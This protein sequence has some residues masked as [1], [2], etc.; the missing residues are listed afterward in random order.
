MPRPRIHTLLALLALAHVVV[1]GAA[2]LMATGGAVRR[3]DT[4]R[5]ALALIISAVALGAVVGAYALARNGRRGRTALAWAVAILLVSQLALAT[6]FKDS[7]YCY[8]DGYSSGLSLSSDEAWRVSLRVCEP[9]RSHHYARLDLTRVEDRRTFTIPV[10][11]RRGSRD[12]ITRRNRWISMR[13]QGGSRYWLSLST[14]VAR[15][16]PQF[17]E[18]RVDLDPPELTEIRHGLELVDG[19]AVWDCDAWRVT[20]GDP[21]AGDPVLGICS[22]GGLVPPE[23]LCLMKRLARECGEDIVRAA[24]CRPELATDPGIRGCLTRLASEGSGWPAWDA[25][26]LIS[27]VADEPARTRELIAEAHDTEA[28]RAAPCAASRDAARRLAVARRQT[29]TSRQRHALVDLLEGR[30]AGEP[31][32]CGSWDSPF[33]VEWSASTARLSWEVAVIDRQWGFLDRSCARARSLFD[34]AGSD[35][36]TQLGD[37]QRRDALEWREVCRGRELSR[38]GI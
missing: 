14:A 34:G 38:R 32:R 5:M 23:R 11:V 21:R 4:A 33:A 30:A 7:R 36:M 15:H 19:R 35:A 1:A 25:L 2:W 20:D 12:A 16:G 3:P 29:S 24:I 28:R 8:E 13:L 17:F 31:Q 9:Y 26:A 22:L 10:P 27:L 37:E 18:L 6:R